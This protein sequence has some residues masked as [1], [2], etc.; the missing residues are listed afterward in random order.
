MARIGR[1]SNSPRPKST[2]KRKAEKAA[3]QRIFGRQALTGAHGI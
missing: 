1:T 3:V 2:T